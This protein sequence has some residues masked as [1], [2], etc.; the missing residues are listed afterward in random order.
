MYKLQWA[1]EHIFV[2]NFFRDI[3]SSSPYSTSKSSNLDRASD[4]APQ[5]EDMD[6]LERRL[7]CKS[8]PSHF[9]IASHRCLRDVSNTFSPDPAAQP[10][11]L[12]IQLSILPLIASQSES[13]P[14]ISITFSSIRGPV[15]IN[16]TSSDATSLTPEILPGGRLQ[17]CWKTICDAGLLGGG[18]EL[19]AWVEKQVNRND[20]G[21]GME[22]DS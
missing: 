4:V 9:N 1:K 8:S 19:M 10:S 12:P 21:G 5:V 17:L 22:V 20:T 3:F 14:S 13:F 2:S 18:R 11:H 15:V 16:L 6:E 7:F